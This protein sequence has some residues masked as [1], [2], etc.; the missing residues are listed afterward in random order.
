MSIYS[1]RDK[2]IDCNAITVH[3]R[4]KEGVEER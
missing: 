3:L 2:L 1:F 4:I